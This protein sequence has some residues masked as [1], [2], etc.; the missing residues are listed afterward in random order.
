ML[1]VEE[2]REIDPKLNDLTDEQVR[3]IRDALY[4]LGQLAIEDWLEK[5]RAGKI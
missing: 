2:C 4:D 1:S 5:K 3:E